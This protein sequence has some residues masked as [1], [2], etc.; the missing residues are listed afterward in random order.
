M[1]DEM[2]VKISLFAM[3]VGVAIVFLAWT[4][5]KIVNYSH[6]SGMIAHYYSVTINQP[7]LM[8]VGIAELIVVLLFLV[9]KFKNI[10]YA[11]VLIAHS[12]TTLVSAWRLLPPYEIHQ[13][14]YFG[15]LPM[16]GACIGLYLMRDKD[17]L[18]TL[19]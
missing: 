12:I 9:G 19:R 17:T 10:T 3:R 15:S 1:S 5:D 2:K 4:I 11:I 7:I 14:L 8:A 18:F 13:L 16:L 6:N